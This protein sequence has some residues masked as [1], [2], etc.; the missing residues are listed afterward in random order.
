MQPFIPLPSGDSSIPKRLLFSMLKG[1][2]RRGCFDL[3]VSFPSGQ[4][5]SL[6]QTLP[7]IAGTSNVSGDLW[8]FFVPKVSPTY[9]Q[10]RTVNLAMVTNKRPS[11]F[12]IY[13][14]QL[15]LMRVCFIPSNGQADI[16]GEP[17]HGPFGR[18]SLNKGSGCSAAGSK[19]LP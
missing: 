13:G 2:F 19:L 5:L 3:T 4:V 12:K 16:N 17:G 1:R 8:L 15:D 11:K 18:S 9:S 7:F 14:L 10:T 6:K